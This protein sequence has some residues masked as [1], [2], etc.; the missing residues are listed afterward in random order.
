MTK[1]KKNKTKE[2]KT[3]K[4]IG[5]LGG[6]PKAML[7]RVCLFCCVFWFWFLWFWLGTPH[8]VLSLFFW[9][10][11]VCFLF[12]FIYSFWLGTPPHGV[13]TLC[14]FCFGFLWFCFFVLDYSF[15][16]GTPPG[17]LNL[18]FLCFFW[19]WFLWF[20]LG[21]HTWSPKSVFFVL[22]FVVLVSLVL[23]LSVSLESYFYM[24]FLAW[25]TVYIY[26]FSMHPLLQHTLNI[27]N[28]KG[29]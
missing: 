23:V 1:I 26:T 3:P 15:W 25:N 22:L 20:W 6:E 7:S 29:F 8:G 14:F 5:T 17:V 4:K 2:N 16:L 19:L 13:L 11:F 9:F 24:F 10:W 18:W 12:W 21:G 28:L 27:Y